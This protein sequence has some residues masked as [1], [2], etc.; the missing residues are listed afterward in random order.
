MLCVCAVCWSEGIEHCWLRGTRERER[1]LRVRGRGRVRGLVCFWLHACLCV[2]VGKAR[3]S[4]AGAERGEEVV[5]RAPQKCIFGCQVPP[6]FV[7]VQHGEVFSWRAVATAGR[8]VC[9]LFWPGIIPGREYR[10]LFSWVA[11]YQLSKPTQPNPTGSDP[12]RPETERDEAKR[13]YFL[14]AKRLL[15]SQG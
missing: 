9:G 13:K 12:I 10:M 8:P 6:A 14:R 11:K 5:L 4:R 1:V 3:L 7:G 15:P 2:F